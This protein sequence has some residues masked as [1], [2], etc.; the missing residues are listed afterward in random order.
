M[1]IL[2]RATLPAATLALLLP[3]AVAM[4]D[5]QIRFKVVNAKTREPLPGAVIKIE[6]TA[7]ELDELQFSTASNGTVATGDL[8][9]GQRNFEVT[10]I[11][12]GLTF[13]PFKG[14]IA[15]VDNQVVDVE[16]LLEEKGFEIKTVDAK[17]LRINV[18]DTS[19][20]TFRDRKFFEMFPLGAGNRQSLPKVLR[21][22]PGF[23]GGPINRI[24]ARGEQDNLGFAIDGFLLPPGTTGQASAL[25]TP[26]IVETLSARTGGY[27]ADLGGASGAILDIG[28]RPAISGD[29]KDPLTPQVAYRL[30][31]GEFGTNEAYLTVSRQRGQSTQRRGDIGYFLALSKRTSGNVLESPQPDRQSVHNGGRSDTLFGKMEMQVSGNATIASIFGI[32]SG[33]TGIAN[34]TGLEALYRPKQGFGFGGAGVVEDFTDD[35]GNVFDQESAGQRIVQKD[36]NRFF[37]SQYRQ[38]FSPSVTGVVSMGYT[39]STQ[40]V[41]NRST[42]YRLQTLAE[43]HPIEYRPTV[44]QDFENSQLQGDFTIAAPGSP[45]K[46]K[47]GFLIRTMTGGEALQ[48]TP[49]SQTALDALNSF[50]PFFTNV[51]NPTILANDEKMPVL[52]VDRKTDYG[53][54]YVQ[55]TWAP[56]E[57][58]RVNVGLRA[59]TYKQTQEFYLGVPVEPILQ[60]SSRT[61]SAVSPRINVLLQVPQNGA[62]GIGKTKVRFGTNQPTALRISYNQIFTPALGQGNVGLGQNPANSA[63]AL[64]NQAQVTDQFDISVERQLRRQSVKL[65]YY[66]KTNRNAIGYQQ[67]IAGPQML[68]Y[69]TLNLGR[70]KASGME[71]TYE[72]NPRNFEPAPG[73]L[74]DYE[75]VAGFLT[76]N[77]GRVRFENGGTPAF[78]Q[79]LTMTAGVGYNLPK[80][81]SVGLSYYY[82]S[83]LAGSIFG[84]SG[85][86]SLSEINLRL[87]SAPNRFGNVGVELGIENL[88]DS[89]SVV[90]FAGDYA[91]TRFQQGRRYVVSIFGKY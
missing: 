86:Q 41:V 42:F 12:N 8:A 50:S 63:V 84:T 44:T 65:G 67:I 43:D 45:H 54:F 72:F 70:T 85:R 61:S 18:D 68:A 13:K 9:S 59:E 6:P 26:D 77:S 57:T 53:A 3:A 46:F 87:A 21:S 30:G 47:T 74:D 73:R 76:L 32:G 62:L 64:P 5:G 66:N 22:V 55:D 91:G 75:G 31:T 25:L 28:L 39:R 79:R 14:R 40:S 37:V 83:G 7:S 10:A 35:D 20:S 49:Q 38:R 80:G 58:V 82:G 51:L 33:R 36:N 78:D 88:G 2:R 34:R 16:V 1:R 23:A 56:K 29:P 19:Q 48:M 27:G 71:L 15:V 69:S 24:H 90:N 52:F 4:A 17:I 60:R 81:D 89:R 11:V